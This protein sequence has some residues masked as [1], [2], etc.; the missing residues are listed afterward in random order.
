[1]ANPISVDITDSGTR[2]GAGM[3]ALLGVFVISG[4]ITNPRSLSDGSW[5]ARACLGGGALLFA[6]LLYAYAGMREMVIEPDAGSM[7]I[8]TLFGEQE[9]QKGEILC[10]F[11]K[12]FRGKVFII[13][14][15]DK[16]EKPIIELPHLEKYE[17]AARKAGLLGGALGINAID[18][19][20]LKQDGLMQLPTMKPQ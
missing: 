20:G 10:V 5:V 7:T 6:G 8:S 3:F 15:L 1:M 19:T 11:V 9:Y 16:N 13:R 18:G 4:I 14:L 12:H 2:Q 17:A